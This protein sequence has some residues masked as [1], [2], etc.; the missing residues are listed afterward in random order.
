MVAMTLLT[1]FYIFTFCLFYVYIGYPACLVF[2]S[3]FKSK[4]EKE[5]YYKPT[6]T[7]VITARNEE[8]IIKDKIQNCLELNY[9]KNLL[10]IIIV[11]DESTDHT[12]D[13]VKTFEDKRIVLLELDKRHGKTAAQNESIQYAKGDILVFSDANAMYDPESIQY[14]AKHF[15]DP[16]VGCVSGE[17]CYSNPK[18]SSVGEEENLYWQYEKFIK[19]QEDKVAT[20]LGAN[21]SIYAVRKSCYVPLEYDIISDFIEPLEI[22][23]NGY[24]VV[25]ESDAKSYE[26]A[27][28]EFEEELSRKRRIVARSIR[29]LIRHRH[30]L[31]PFRSPVLA[32][33]LISHK[34]LRWL[35]PLFSSLILTLNIGLL[36]HPF[37][38]S[39]FGLQIIFYLWA[40]AGHL[41]RNQ[42][43][44]PGWFMA[45]YYIC[46]LGVSSLLGI[47]DV[48]RGRKTIFWEPIRSS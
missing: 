33:E 24:T 28:S 7:L 6:V 29:S 16:K 1:L 37:Y 36:D 41:V 11:S 9:P 21:G 20:I 22:A 18:G 23:S 15:E 47:W 8:R 40:F 14:L 31:N 25:Y 46:L 17:L 44:L 10:D 48:I 42:V 5:S 43:K 32:F 26:E 3:M 45:P 39:L 4:E 35:S 34:V 12:N 13:Y 27:C 30:L 19:K 38:L 2:L